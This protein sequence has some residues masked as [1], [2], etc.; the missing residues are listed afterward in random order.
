MRDRGV[1]GR[2]KLLALF[3]GLLCTVLLELLEIP[4]ETVVA[5]LLP[6]VGPAVDLAIDGAEFVLLPLLLAAAFMPH[7]QKRQAKSIRH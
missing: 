3:I 7:L 1:P 2:I 6:F 4:L 5:V